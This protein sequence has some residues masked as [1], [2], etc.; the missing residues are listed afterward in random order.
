MR[1][2]Q[3]VNELRAASG[4]NELAVHC[5]EL[6]ELESD[7]AFKEIKISSSNQRMDLLGTRIRAALP[8]AT[9][10]K[11]P[12]IVSLVG[13][14]A[15]SLKEVG[16]N[17]RA[18]GAIVIDCDQL[19]EELCNQEDGK[20]DASF[21]AAFKD[22]SPGLWPDLRLKIKAQVAELKNSPV[23]VLQGN[24]LLQAGWQEDCH[25]V[26]AV[27]IPVKEVGSCSSKSYNAN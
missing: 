2:G 9:L 19:A 12:Y 13:G 27:I 26:W 20:K 5:I 21:D 25:E 10:P 24:I 14:V 3:K 7:S 17:L 22:N 15:T 4:L 8:N 1:G 23:V 11:L 6:V 18:R 16:E